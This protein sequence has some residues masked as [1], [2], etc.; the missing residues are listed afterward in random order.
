VLKISDSM[1][2]IWI[3]LNLMNVGVLRVNA[4]LGVLRGMY[5][6]LDLGFVEFGFL[7]FGEE[8]TVGFVLFV[9]ER[10][11]GFVK[12]SLVDVVDIV[13]FTSFSSSSCF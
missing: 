4:S 5:F 7:R 2:L 13:D 9:F 3:W 8:G 11:I 10:G 12:G 6:I 1:F